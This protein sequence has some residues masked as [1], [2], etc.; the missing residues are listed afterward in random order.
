M[1]VNAKEKK[2]LKEL[3]KLLLDSTSPKF[4]DKSEP[5]EK[6]K[7]DYLY[8]FLK[9]LEEETIE[10]SLNIKGQSL[11]VL[12]KGYE[13]QHLNQIGLNIFDLMVNRLFEEFILGQM[14]MEEKKEYYLSKEPKE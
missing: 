8:N 3:K 10:L 5:K 14:S 2:R 11:G 9:D 1:N 13:I 7:K 4:E 6:T 12:F